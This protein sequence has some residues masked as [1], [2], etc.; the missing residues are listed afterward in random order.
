MKLDEAIERLCTVRE[1][2]GASANTVQALT[3]DLASLR[4]FAE[5]RGVTET[6]GLDLELLRDWLWEATEQGRASATIAR[7]GASARA[8]G[9]MLADDGFVNPAARLKTPKGGRTLPRVASA[10]TMHDMLDAAH[11]AANEGDP[12]T[13]R[14]AAILELLYAT[15]ARVSEIVGL[16]VDDIDLDRRTVRVM[17]K[18]AKER[19]V[20]FGAPA[21]AAMIDWLQRG[22]PE[23]RGS[24]SGGPACF[25]GVRGGRIGARQIYALVSRE[26]GH[27]PGSGPAGPHTL[28]HTAATH[29]L[30]GGADL[31]AVQELLGHADLG[32]TQIYTHVSLER[33]RDAYRNAHPRA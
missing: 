32:T 5:T 18:G 30:D 6:E 16:D 24:G 13:L 9:R 12:A 19:V 15:G 3:R 7:R 20:P 2:D 31:R 26:L 17:G 22:R 1:R 14:D 4:A 21:H 28:R 33:V 23:L 25:L 29:L 8:L 11:I 27:A 10:R